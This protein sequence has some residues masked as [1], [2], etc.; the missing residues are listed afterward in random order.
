[1][2][3]SLAAAGKRNYNICG[4][5]GLAVL[6]WHPEGLNIMLWKLLIALSD[7]IIDSHDFL[8]I[9]VYQNSFVGA[10]VNRVD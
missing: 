6:Y 8:H 1:M 4:F 5:P 9:R 2:N 10:S 3:A 7:Q